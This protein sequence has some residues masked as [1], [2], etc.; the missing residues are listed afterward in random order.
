MPISL[1]ETLGRATPD[2][3]SAMLDAVL[4]VV[5]ADALAGHFHDTGGFAINNVAASLDLGLR[6]FDGA[7][8]GLGGCPY[9]PGAPGNVATEALVN[10]LHQ[11]GYDTGVDP[12]KLET[13]AALARTMRGGRNGTSDT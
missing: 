4:Q 7:V 1:G 11:R 10:M 8:G 13:A 2:R 6:A 3:V 9:A 12:A 5:P